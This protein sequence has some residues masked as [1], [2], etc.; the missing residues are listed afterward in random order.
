MSSKED[1]HGLTCP[2]CGGVV[3][4]PEGQVIIRCPYCD[5][6]S[7]VR[8]EHGLRR[9]QVPLRVQ[10]EQAVQA[11]R[12]FLSG[13]WAIARDAPHQARLLEAMIV[14]LPFWTVWVRVGAW[15]F[16]EKRVGSGDDRRY[17]PREVRIVQE[18]TWNGAACDVGEF[19]VTRVPSVEQDLE[20]FE[21]ESL[22]HSG[23]VFEPVSSFDEARTKAEEQFQDQVRRKAGLDRL[24]QLFVRFLRRRY[25]LVYHPLWVLRYLYRG[26]GFQVVVDA[27]TGKVLYGKAPGNTL[28]RAGILVLGMAVGALVA[29][30]GPAILLSGLSDSNDGLGILA[31]AFFILLFGFGIMIAA[32]RAFRYGEQYEY[33]SDAPTKIAGL[34]NP[35]EIVTQVKDVEQ[36]INRLS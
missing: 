14:H 21:P 1:L 8:G 26:R 23:L 34:E 11:L 19:G 27:F 12:K 9:F 20:P 35:L 7:F 32:Y 16:G 25:T 22:H 5:L 33:R 4:V 30:D 17:E 29:I 28:Y 18:M 15:A 13:N 2:R 10:R 31:F 36:W 24:A 3:S 6:R